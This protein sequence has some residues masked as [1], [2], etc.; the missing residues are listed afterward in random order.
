MLYILFPPTLHA[1][2][3]PAGWIFF[4]LAQNVLVGFYVSLSQAQLQRRLYSARMPIAPSSYAFCC[5]K[6]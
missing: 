3:V 6:L 1:L 4:L 2:E 5:A